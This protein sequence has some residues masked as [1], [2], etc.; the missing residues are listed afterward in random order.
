MPLKSNFNLYKFGF[1]TLPANNIFL[2][3][4]SF[5]ILIILPNW[6]I[7]KEYEFLSFLKVFFLVKSIIKYFFLFLIRS[8]YSCLFSGEQIGL[9]LSFSIKVITSLTN[10]LSLYSPLILFKLSCRF[11]EAKIS[12]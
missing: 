12:L 5:K 4:F 8:Y 9:F 11:F 3:S 10:S 7:D 1:L 6:P 2:Q